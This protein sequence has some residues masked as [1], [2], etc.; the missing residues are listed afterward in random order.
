M[1]C[2][3]LNSRLLFNL[4]KLAFKQVCVIDAL[5]TSCTGSWVDD[6]PFS[7]VSLFNFTVY[8]FPDQELMRHLL[9]E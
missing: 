8:L 2:R 5:Y 7:L 9:I 6:T 1:G 4:S 3:D